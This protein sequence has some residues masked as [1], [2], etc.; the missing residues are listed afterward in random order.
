ME[1]KNIK[2]IKPTRQQKLETKIL[3]ESMAQ[4]IKNERL[5]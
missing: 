4:L 1:K 3:N 2:Y 5:F